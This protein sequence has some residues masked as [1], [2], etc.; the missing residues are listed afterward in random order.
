M[1]QAYIVAGR[2]LRRRSIVK[3]RPEDRAR[4]AETGRVTARFPVEWPIPEYRPDLAK[5][6][7]EA[8]DTDIWGPGPYL[9]VPNRQGD[10]EVV[11]RVFCPWGYPPDRLRLAR[12]RTYLEIAGVALDRVGEAAWEWRLDLRPW[13]EGEPE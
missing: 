12:S 9:K 8:G 11:N 7:V 6:Y 10:T 4:L 3:L 2:K 5:A 13:R 1:A